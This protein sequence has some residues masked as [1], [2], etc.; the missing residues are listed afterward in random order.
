MKHIIAAVTLL[1]LSGCAFIMPRPHDPVMFGDMVEVKLALNKLNCVDKSGWEPTFSKVEKLKTYATLR[2]DPQA[3]ALSDLENALKKAHET[4]NEKFCEG[5]VKLQKT[6][7]EV[8][9]N[10]W[11]GR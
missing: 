5:V 9:A 8:L 7:V 1:F 6:R 4:K 11:R 10:A 3:E 2:K